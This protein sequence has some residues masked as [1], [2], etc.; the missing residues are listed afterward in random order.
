MTALNLIGLGGLKESGKD[1]AAKALVDELGWRKDSVSLAIDSFTRLVDPFV[2]V[3][4][5]RGCRLVRYSEYVDSETYCGGDFDLA[6][7]HPEIRRLLQAVGGSVRTVDA[8]AWSS[9]AEQ[10]MV[11]TLSAGGG[12]AMTGVRFQTE[13]DVVRRHGGLLVWVSR[14]DHDDHSDTDVTENSVGPEDFD[15]VIVNDGTLE[16]LRAQILD[17]VR[18]I[19]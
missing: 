5:D 13:I 15:I 18:S 1:S 4:A 14:P 7:K 9:R 11:E 6:K 17:L 10:R 19:I 2:L 12:Y 3:D 8:E 16:E